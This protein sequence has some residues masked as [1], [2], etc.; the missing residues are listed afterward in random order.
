MERII[1]RAVG[2]GGT[3]PKPTG[4]HQTRPPPRHPQV[5]LC[6]TCGS[7][8]YKIHRFSRKPQNFILPQDLYFLEKILSQLIANKILSPKN[9]V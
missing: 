8:C 7:C 5:P 9:F 6:Y 4:A 1:Q 2:V 3:P